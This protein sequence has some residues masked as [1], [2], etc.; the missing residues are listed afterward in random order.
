MAWNT[1][2]CLARWGQPPPPGCAPSWSPV[3]IN[4]VLAK[5]RT[6]SHLLPMNGTLYYIEVFS[7]ILAAFPNDFMVTMDF[8]IVCLRKTKRLSLLSSSIVFIVSLCKKKA[9]C[10]TK[11][12]PIYEKVLVHS[13]KVNINIKLFCAFLWKHTVHFKSFEVFFLFI[14]LASTLKIKYCNTSPSQ[15]ISILYSLGRMFLICTFFCV[16]CVIPRIYGNS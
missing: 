13:R 2:L 7:S 16:L 8:Y 14:F 6:T 12:L 10:N 15:N 5:P 4:P 11:D 1:G 9:T 3:K